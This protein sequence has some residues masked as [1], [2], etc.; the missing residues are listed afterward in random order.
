MK[1]VFKNSWVQIISLG[2]VIG[3]V[4]IVLDN[5]FK[6]FESKKV[7]SLYKGPIEAD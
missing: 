2:L 7:E 3:F 4:F 6:F 1:K 5:K